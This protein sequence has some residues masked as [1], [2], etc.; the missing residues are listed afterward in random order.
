M[1]YIVMWNF[2]FQINDWTVWLKHFKLTPH[3]LW[4]RTHKQWL[5]WH[6]VK[7]TVHWCNFRHHCCHCPCHPNYRWHNVLCPIP[8]GTGLLLE[9]P[10]LCEAHCRRESQGSRSRRRKRRVSRIYNLIWNKF[11]LCIQLT[12]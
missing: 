2:L 6:C 4:T 3:R 8:L 11:N 5:P 9:K 10:R 1:I 7:F 12:F